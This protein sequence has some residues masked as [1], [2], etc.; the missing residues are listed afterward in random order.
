MNMDIRCLGRCLLQV[1]TA[2]FRVL[3]PMML[4]LGFAEPV[5]ATSVCAPLLTVICMHV[6]TFRLVTFFMAM[7]WVCM[8]QTSGITR[9]A[10]STVAAISTLLLA[11]ILYNSDWRSPPSIHALARKLKRIR[12]MVSRAPE[13]IWMRWKT[14]PRSSTLAFESVP[15]LKKTRSN[16]SGSC[17]GAAPSG[18]GAALQ[19]RKVPKGDQMV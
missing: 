10:V 17:L 11:V 15:W 5:L 18:G 16:S 13:E 2:S 7:Y 3:T 19:E 14:I 12:R 1:G 6:F 4:T 9:A 8:H